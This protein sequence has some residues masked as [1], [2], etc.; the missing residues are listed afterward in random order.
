MRSF[1]IALAIAAIACAGG[2]PQ[3]PA[4]KPAAPGPAFLWK[5]ERAG[6]VLWLYGTLHDAGLDAVPAVAIAAFESSRRLIT[7]LG[8]VS[9]DPDVFR[10]HARIASGPGIDQRLPADDWWDLR[11]ALLG[12]LD[13][14]D[15][16]RAKPWYAMS[17]LTTY[18]SPS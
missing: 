6:A 11:D 17:L 9:P 5:V 18:A 2:K 8:D 15:L 3:C 12:K 10:A 14:D 1:A 16:R 13:E 7:E 4:F